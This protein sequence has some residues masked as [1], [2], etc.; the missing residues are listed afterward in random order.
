M[1]KRFNSALW[2]SSLL[3]QVVHERYGRL[4][5]SVKRWFEPEY[6]KE[7]NQVI[8]GEFADASLNDLQPGA[9]PAVDT[10]FNDDDLFFWDSA[11]WEITRELIIKL[12]TEVE[13]A[14]SRLVLLHFPSEGLASSGIPLPHEEFDAFLAHNGIPHVSLF[15]D[16]YALD[17]EALGK[18]FI[19]AD[20]HWTR[21]GHQY[22][23]RRTQDMLFSA[24]SGQ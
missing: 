11:G 19:P 16:Y 12:K 18:H 4:E 22:V 10:D 14:G 1:R 15:P 23:A 21:H 3:Y 6:R 24:L 17:Q 9:G 2:N 7:I 8:A 20:G 5:R 13:A